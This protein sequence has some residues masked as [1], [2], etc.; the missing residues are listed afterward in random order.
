MPCTS[1]KPNFI[2]NGTVARV[3]LNE[4]R[5]RNGKLQ[6]SKVQIERDKEVQPDESNHCP[7]SRNDGSIHDA[8]NCAAFLW[9]YST[10][11][12]SSEICVCK[13]KK[14]SIASREAI[15]KL[16]P[17][18]GKLTVGQRDKQN[19]ESQQRYRVRSV[20]IFN[21]CSSTCTTLE[22]NKMIWRREGGSAANIL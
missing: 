1:V 16:I 6:Q 22:V 8:D 3:L 19:P 13:R 7:E 2:R 14:L 18:G 15:A 11:C 21:L 10:V 17:P 20:Q 9:H 12:I 5:E 4:V